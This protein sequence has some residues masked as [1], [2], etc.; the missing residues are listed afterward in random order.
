MNQPLIF[1]LETFLGLFALALLLRFYLQ[2]VRAPA[3]N[4][5]SNFIAALTNF[6]VIPTR[7]VVPGLWGYDLSSL[8]LALLVK[9]VLI[10]LVKVLAGFQ[11][12]AH[13]LPV[14]LLAGVGL[15][16]VFVYIVMF[17]TVVQ[18][19]LSWVNPYSP[20]MPVLTSMARPFLRVFQRYVPPIGG[21]DLSPLFVLVACQLVLMWP[22]FPL[23][24]ALNGLFVRAP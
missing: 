10:G 8:L 15:L 7:R 13:L 19:V 17:V 1:L 18:A 16:R 21:V 4:P 6:V 14:L 2:A 22:V 20:A 12:G 5:L 23:E 11:V 9:A 3:R 24:V